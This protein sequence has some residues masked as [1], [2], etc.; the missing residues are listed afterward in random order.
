V[1]TRGDFMKPELVSLYQGGRL[2]DIGIWLFKDY[3][4]SEEFF[5][6]L[7]GEF[8]FLKTGRDAAI[9]SFVDALASLAEAANPM[10]A[11]SFW[12]WS[13][14]GISLHPFGLQRR[15]GRVNTPLM[16]RA[17]HD[18]LASLPPDAVARQEPQGVAV[19]K[20]FPEFAEV[21]FYNEMARPPVQRVSAWSRAVNLLDAFS[22][23]G[24]HAIAQLPAVLKMYGSGCRGSGHTDALAVLIYLSQLSYCRDASN[25]AKILAEY[26]RLCRRKDRE[27]QDAGF[28]ASQ[29]RHQGAENTLLQTR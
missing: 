24:G 17:L 7:H 9:Q 1:L 5:E 26:E 12:N 10:T 2:A 19:R 14:R 4:P 21:P 29:S 20:A 23:I 15:I 3:G 25:A 13:R 28:S 6:L 27:C 11:M 22:L 18:F 16:D 8:A